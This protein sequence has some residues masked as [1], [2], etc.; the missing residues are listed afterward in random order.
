[1]RNLIKPLSPKQ[2]TVIAVVVFV[3]VFV[4]YLI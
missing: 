3:A 1:M 2:A 4:G